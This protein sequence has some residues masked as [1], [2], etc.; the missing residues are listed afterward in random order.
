MQALMAALASRKLSVIGTSAGARMTILDESLGFGIEEGTKTVEH[1]TS[2]T[3]QKL[4]D[5][6]LGYQVPKGRR[7]GAANGSINRDLTP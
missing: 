5:R 1:R 4:I 6:G 7:G 3:D 2:F